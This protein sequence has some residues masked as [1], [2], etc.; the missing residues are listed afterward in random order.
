MKNYGTISGYFDWRKTK[1][2]FG[3][4]LDIHGKPIFRNHPKFKNYNEYIE[5]ASV[6]FAIR[7]REWGYLIR[8]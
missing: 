3:S 5:D 8:E 4:L 6:T 1:T 7:P 2:G